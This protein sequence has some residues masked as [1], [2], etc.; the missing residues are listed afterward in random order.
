MLDGRRHVFRTP[1]SLSGK[2][3]D[4]CPKWRLKPIL[5]LRPSERQT[6]V[7]LRGGAIPQFRQDLRSRNCMA[8]LVM[9]YECL[10]TMRGH[11]QNGSRLPRGATLLPP[12]YS[13]SSGNPAR[14]LHDRQLLLLTVSGLGRELAIICHEANNSPPPARLDRTRKTK[15][16]HFSGENACKVDRHCFT[17]VILLRSRLVVT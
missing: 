16:H 3:Q 14:A 5:A 7:L 11:G 12:W 8:K 1:P 2:T 6:R 17:R 4:P 15:P 13:Q 10:W 9:P